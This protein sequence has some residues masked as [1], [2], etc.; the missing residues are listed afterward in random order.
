MRSPRLKRFCRSEAELEQ[1]RLTL[2]L[3]ACPHCKC[4]GFLIGHG[5]M[6]GYADKGND[7]VVRG[8]R[9]FCSN[10]YR[11]RG[12]GRTFALCLAEVLCGFMVRA[13]TLWDYFLG[14]SQGQSRKAAWESAGAAFSLTSGYRLWRAFEQA[15]AKIRALLCRQCPPPPSSTAQPLTQLIEHMQCAFPSTDCPLELFHCRFQTSLI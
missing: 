12:C 5:L 9:V 10:R 14:V 7:R 4:V 8:R 15:Q 6:W 2:K 1:A 11:R 13:R 3:V